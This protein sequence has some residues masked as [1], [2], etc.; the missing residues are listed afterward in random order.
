MQSKCQCE[1]YECEGFNE[2][3]YLDQLVVWNTERREVAIF[4]VNRSG[5]DSQ[6]V[7]TELQGMAPVSVAGAVSLFAK[8]KKMTNYIDHNAVRPEKF[9]AVLLQDDCVTA[10]LPPLSF[11]VIRIAVQK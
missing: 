5:T 4:L 8:D 10:Q 1:S 7:K 9:E 3:P 2:V 11:V 6:E